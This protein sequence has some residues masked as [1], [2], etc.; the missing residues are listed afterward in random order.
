MDVLVSFSPLKGSLAIVFGT[1]WSFLETDQINL[2]IHRVPLMELVS[3]R[4]VKAKLRQHGDID[5]PLVGLLQEVLQLATHDRGGTREILI[6]EV[7]RSHSKY[8]LAGT[9][10]L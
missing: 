3:G 6:F 2:N 7:E 9:V 4:N 8:L 5:S 1:R 10:V